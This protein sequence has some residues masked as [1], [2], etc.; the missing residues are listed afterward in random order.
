MPADFGPPRRISQGEVYSKCHVQHPDNLNSKGSSR[1][2]RGQTWKKGRRTARSADNLR[3]HAE[4]EQKP[5]GFNA[6][7]SL[8]LAMWPG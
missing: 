8:Q 6:P 4:E 2:P 1:R 7:K 3:P 5:A